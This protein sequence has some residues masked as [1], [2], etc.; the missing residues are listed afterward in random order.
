[1]Q[2]Q[3][4]ERWL[5]VGVMFGLGAM[6]IYKWQ[7]NRL[8]LYIHPRYTGL[9]VATAV[10]LLLAAVGMALTKAPAIPKRMLALLTIPVAFA[11]LVPAR[12]LGANLVSG[13][14]LNANSSDNL[15]ARWKTNLSDDSKSWTLLEW[16]TAVRQSDLEVLRDKQAAFEGFVYRTPDLPADEVLVGRYVVTCCTADGTA[17]SLRVKATNGADF[18][19]D[20]WVRVEGTFV[21]AEINGSIVPQ[22]AGTLVSI[23]MPSSPY[24]YP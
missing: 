10:V 1:M 14:A 9:L 17:L 16:T 11:L 15:L 6:I 3:V 18:S 20:Q 19:N 4:L 24:L 5:S 21:P 22:I 12:P 13:K 7:T 2:R 23:E 8:N